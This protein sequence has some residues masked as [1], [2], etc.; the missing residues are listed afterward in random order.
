VHI[1]GYSGGGGNAM[2]ALT[3]FPDYFRAGSSY[4]GI[5][6]YGYVD[7]VGWY[8]NGAGSGHRSQLRTDIG[9][10]TQE[11]PDVV[12]RYHARASSLAAR[13]NPYSEIHLFV[14]D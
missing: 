2:S 12:D 11:D 3:K 4:F 6:D 7:G 9:D 14:N 13:N 1:T 10:P 5:S 8:T